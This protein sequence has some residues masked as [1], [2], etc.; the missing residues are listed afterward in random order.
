MKQETLSKISIVFLAIFFCS[1]YIFIWNILYDSLWPWLER[2]PMFNQKFPLL[3]NPVLL[4]ILVIIF[5]TGII[6]AKG[7]GWR[8][9]LFP[10]IF[11]FII[12]FIFTFI[13]MLVTTGEARWFCVL[14]LSSFGVIFP[15]LLSSG[16]IFY[17]FKEKNIKRY[18]IVNVILIL[19]LLSVSIYAKQNLSPLTIE[20]AIKTNEIKNCERI[21]GWGASFYKYECIIEIAKEKKEDSLCQNIQ[22]EE[23]QKYCYKQIAIEEKNPTLCD[24]GGNYPSDCIKRIAVSLSDKKICEKIEHPIIKQ[25]CLEEIEGVGMR[26]YFSEEYGFQIKYPI[27][28]EF[29]ESNPHDSPYLIGKVSGDEERCCDVPIRKTPDNKAI[30]GATGAFN[31]DAELTCDTISSTFQFPDVGTQSYTACGCGCCK[32]G[33]NELTVT[34]LYHSKGDDI[35]KIIDDD[36]KTAQN[37]LCPQKKICNHPIKYIYCD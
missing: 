11:L 36:K 20:E 13:C 2:I 37:S 27:Y 6:F 16:H 25:Q 30:L 10:L 12:G 34:C 24:K 17:F 22:H 8:I 28:C 4:P 3:I 18:I 15:Y 29:N 1:F 9:F 35:Q 23:W 19:L 31:I 21:R 5:V 14:T 26:T 32:G 33:I 7:K